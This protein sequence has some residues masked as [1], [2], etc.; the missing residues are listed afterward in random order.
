MFGSC[1][2]FFR[3]GLKVGE[4][5]GPHLIEV[6]AQ[7]G[8]TLGVKLIEAARTGASVEHESRVF[9]HFQVLRDSRAAHRESAC[10]FVDGE[11]PTRE[12]LQNGH[13]RGIAKSVKTGLEVNVH[14][15]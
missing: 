15:L 1:E 11:R 6:S 9:E 8:H 7:P 2:R 13:A 5:L 12:F 10:E 4:G 14:I 3:G